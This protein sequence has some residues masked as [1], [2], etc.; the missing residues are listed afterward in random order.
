MKKSYKT[1]KEVREMIEEENKRILSYNQPTKA[2]TCKNLNG[3]LITQDVD[4]KLKFVPNEIGKCEVCTLSHEL[5]MKR[6]S[7]KEKNVKEL[8]AVYQKKNK[9]E[10]EKWTITMKSKTVL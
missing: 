3:L 4:L 9:K 2:H 1:L 8:T 10:N 7:N 6:N 5:L